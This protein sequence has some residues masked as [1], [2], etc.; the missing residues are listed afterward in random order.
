MPGP[1]APCM[2]GSM[3]VSKMQGIQASGY[4]QPGARAT[5]RQV[6]AGGSQAGQPPGRSL[7]A[8]T[9]CARV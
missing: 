8:D 2:P 1:P 7:G 4:Q 3:S 9:D 6:A 5:G